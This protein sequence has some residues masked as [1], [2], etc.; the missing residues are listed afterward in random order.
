MKT[1]L[2]N[3]DIYTG[4]SI[5][6]DK[7]LLL[8]EGQIA[9]FFPP[10][11]ISAAK[12]INLQG[13]SVAPGFIDLQVNGGGGVLF[14]DSPTVSGIEAI[15]AAHRAYGT[16]RLL[17]TYI[18]GPREGMSAA[19]QAIR[20]AAEKGVKGVLGL[21]LE[22]PFLNPAK[23]G[24]HDKSFMRHPSDVDLQV[25]DGLEDLVCLM[26]LAPEQVERD[27][28]KTLSRKG[29]LVSLGHSNTTYD[30]AIDA[31]RSGA[32]L[33]T[34]LFN[35]MSSFQSREPGLVG[36]ALLS[37]SCWTSVIADGFH[38]HFAS[39]KV[40]WN[41]K[42]PRKMFLVTDAMPPVGAASSD[43]QL[44][45]YAVTVENGRCVTGEGVL[46]GSALDMAT[47]VRNCV[48]KLGIPLDEALRMASTYPSEFARC[49]TR[50]GKIA[51]GFLAD[52]VVFDGQ[53][54]IK[55]TFVEGEYVEH[56]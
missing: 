20:M 14:N 41:A 49:D 31:F 12:T 46:A 55:A 38:I 1:L 29:I 2:T 44:G 37:D 43:F 34:H 13:L 32:T 25:F 52:L 15:V 4:D 48:Q 39:L 42:A 40:A 24:V 54:N 19:V 18:T 27:F 8:E 7:D 17:P 30:Q 23:A 9:G 5:I 33:A 22:G 21:H 26:T 28:I 53:I 50:L 35:A 45:P 51:P 10:A 11:S 3:C 16:T 6:Y 36:A 47:A 56:R